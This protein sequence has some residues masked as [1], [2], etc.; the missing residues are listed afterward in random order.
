MINQLQSNIV[1]G[2]R[3]N[4]SRCPPTAR[5]ATSASAGWATRRSIVRTATFN[6]DVASFY[7]KWMR[8]VDDAQQGN[9]AFSDTSPNGGFVGTGTP[10]WGDA[11]VIVPWTIY[12]AYGD[13]GILAEHY[14][15]MARWIDYIQK[16]N[17]GGLWLAQRGSDFGDWLAIDA[18]SQQ[19]KDIVATAF[20]ATASTSWRA[21]RRCS[22]RTPTPRPT[23]R[24]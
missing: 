1:W 10:A 8:D 5:S 23:P 7:T 19:D 9:G 24:C 15:A 6:M 4:S 22:A 3:G 12:L 2:Q 20:Y 11:G 18:Y 21:R 13:T 17:P 16:A 14:A